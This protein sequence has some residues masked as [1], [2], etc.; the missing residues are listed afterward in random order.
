MGSE[1]HPTCGAVDS[2]GPNLAFRKGT[3]VVLG[4]QLKEA[5]FLSGR[6]F[7]PAH[8]FSEC[9]IPGPVLVLDPARSLC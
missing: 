7:L 1:L 2:Y 3:P 6:P 8:N 9:S 5:A 4:K